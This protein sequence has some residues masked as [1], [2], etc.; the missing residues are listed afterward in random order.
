MSEKLPNFIFGAI[1]R[2]KRGRASSSAASQR[3]NCYT[4]ASPDI[5]RDACVADCWV[6]DAFGRVDPGLNVSPIPV[7]CEDLGRIINTVAQGQRL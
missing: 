5:P 2:G 3:F 4:P 6:C 1:Y 7:R